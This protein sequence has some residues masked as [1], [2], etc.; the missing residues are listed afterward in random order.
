MKFS[1]GGNGLEPALVRQL[2][3]IELFTPVSLNVLIH[4]I[5]S[6]IVRPKH[7]PWIGING[8]APGLKF[9]PR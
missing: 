3:T 4:E 7:D 2:K 8:E 1:F 9:S 5:E 6:G